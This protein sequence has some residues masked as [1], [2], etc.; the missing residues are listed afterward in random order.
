MN[1]DTVLMCARTT[2]NFQRSGLGY[3]DPEVQAL[4]DE[5]TPAPVVEPV[6][7]EEAPAVEEV[8]EEAAEE[9]APVTK[10]KKAK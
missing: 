9:S 7:E 5:L 10:S 3:V 2:A 4:I 6:V 1:L 8:A